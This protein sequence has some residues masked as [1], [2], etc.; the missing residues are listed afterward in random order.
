MIPDSDIKQKLE[1]SAEDYK[2]RL[3][4]D[5]NKTASDLQKGIRNALLIGG[6]MALGYGLYNIFFDEKKEGDESK[7]SN[8]PKGSGI[9]DAVVSAGGE[10]LVV[11]LLSY[12]KQKLKD[13]IRDLDN[14]ESQKEENG[15]D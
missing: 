6:G 2:Q 12:A 9:L 10:L 8:T 1:E 5:L 4:E 15:Q 3:E 13:Y 14:L 11:F 7:S